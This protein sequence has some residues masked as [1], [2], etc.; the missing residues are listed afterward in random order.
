MRTL[1]IALN[2]LFLAMF[3]F[4]VAV[5]FNDPDPVRWVAIYGFAAIACIG[6]LTRNERWSLP[7][8]ICLIAL[9]WA[10]SVV[11]HVHG[12]SIGDLF[13]E[14]EMKNEMIEQAREAGGLMIVALWMAVLTVSAFRRSRRNSP[15]PSQPAQHA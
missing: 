13:A 11:Q 12:V 14:F 7:A 6:E 4:S 10:A 9:S 8:G 15:V 5:Q 3:L 1:W 2:L